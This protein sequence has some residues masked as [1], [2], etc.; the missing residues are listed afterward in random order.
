MIYMISY[1][2]YHPI[3]L[4][5]IYIYLFNDTTLSE[6]IH[7]LAPVHWHQSVV[8]SWPRLS[9]RLGGPSPQLIQ[10]IHQKSEDGTSWKS[11]FLLFVFLLLW[12]FLDQKTGMKTTPQAIYWSQMD[13]MLASDIHLLLN[14]HKSI[15]HVSPSS[16]RRTFLWAQQHILWRTSSRCC[17]SE[18]VVWAFPE[19][20]ETLVP[21]GNGK[22]DPLLFQ[23]LYKL[24]QPQKG[25]DHDRWLSTRKH[26]QDTLDVFVC[27]YVYKYTHID[28]YTVCKGASLGY[29]PH[30]FSTM[31]ESIAKTNENVARE[32]ANEKKLFF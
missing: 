2:W 23:F 32:K 19:A 14:L 10:E 3:V 26:H 12:N 5:Y 20:P 25:V 18:L 11:D 8:A 29:H 4:I 30:I 16:S 15:K 13:S 22:V 31:A 28:T 6:K 1:H 17:S 24:W 9:P 7:C 21:Q 27:V